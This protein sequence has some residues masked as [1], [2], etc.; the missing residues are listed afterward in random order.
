[1]ILTITTD[2]SPFAGSV[3]LLCQLLSPND[4]I[5]AEQRV[6][7]IDTLREVKVGIPITSTVSEGRVV[8]YPM[9]E[10]NHDSGCGA[11][12]AR[13]LGG[14]SSHVVGVGL[15]TF[16]F[17][18]FARI[19][20]VYRQFYTPRGPLR[21]AEQTGETIIRH[22]WDAGIML[23]AAATCDPVSDLP[24]SLRQL[25]YSAFGDPQPMHI[26][27]LGGGVG[28]LG[29]SIAVAFP[30]AQVVVTDLEDAQSL[31]EENIHI[32]SPQHVHLERNVSFRILDWECQ[33][34]PSW[35]QTEQFDLIVMA[36]VTYNTA[37]FVALANTLEHLLL[38]GSKG[39]KILCCGKRRHDEEEGFWQIIH[40]KG[41]IIHERVVFGI[42]LEG[43][44]RYCGNN[45]SEEGEQL[46]DF[47]LMGLG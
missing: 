29:I 35:T 34:F 10:G 31:V 43:N 8:V 4:T 28:I 18:T 19:D 46:I 38:T 16:S 5:L 39:A 20:T 25:V 41:F 6:E 37:T 23:S 27:E 2:F 40:E 30:R 11:F 47:V 1:M 26:L 14:H 44:F 36:D 24:D 33:P 21:I 13:F 17:N 15:A 3:D 7:W 9:R 32:N 45:E 22:V 42:N 12:L